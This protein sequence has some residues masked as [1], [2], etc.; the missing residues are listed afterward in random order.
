LLPF[1]FQLVGRRLPEEQ[2]IFKNHRIGSG[3]ET[4]WSRSMGREH[5]LTGVGGLF[6]CLFVCVCVCVKCLVVEHVKSDQA[7]IKCVII[8][9]IGLILIYMMVVMITKKETDVVRFVNFVCNNLF[10]PQVDL[11]NWIVLFT[12]RDAQIGH[13][14]IQCIQQVSPTMGWQVV[15]P[16]IL[17][18]V[19]DRTE[20]YLN[21][22]RANLT[23][24]T[25]MVVAIF[26]TSRD[27]RYNAFKKLCCVEAPVPSQV[28]V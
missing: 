21:A 18:L 26:P 1:V 3:P 7:L 10:I 13:S 20:S 15:R 11:T 28:S 27:D 6:Y 22:I 8:I 19:N 23:P 14:F 4:D 2:I 24:N 12:K 16:V 17:E 9:L 25:Q 5:V